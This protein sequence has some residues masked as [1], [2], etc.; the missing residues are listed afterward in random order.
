MLHVFSTSTASSRERRQLFRGHDVF[1]VTQA[2]RDLLEVKFI[3]G[4]PIPP[5]SP[6]EE[7]EENEI[8]DETAKYGDV[9]RLD[10]LVLGENM[11][12]GKTWSWIRHVGREGGRQAWWVIKCDDDTLPIIPNLLPFLI[13]QDP[14]VPTY[15]G[16]S[17]GRW[18]GY[19][20]YFEGMMYGFS[21]GVVKTLATAKVPELT[22]NHD[23]PEDARIGE[24]MYSL[25]SDPALCSDKNLPVLDST[26][27]GFCDPTR[28]PPHGWSLPPRSPDPRTGLIRLDLDHKDRTFREPWAA[29]WRT[30]LAWHW[31]KSDEDYLAALDMV[32]EGFKSIGR[33]YVWAVPKRMMWLAAPSYSEGWES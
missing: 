2:Y 30:A 27:P 32:I 5:L 10:G 6:D 8:R 12:Q 7:A 22:R 23:M 19:H 3:L 13:R 17:L 29:S 28:P 25:P 14:S 24:L 18:P 31:L 4:R 15:F 16:T 11:N 33:D 9:V 21:W 20:Y 1:N 26:R